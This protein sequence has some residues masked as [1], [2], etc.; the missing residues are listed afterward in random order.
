MTDLYA[1][2]G[3]P[4]SHSKSPLI[5]K[6]FAEVLGQD[7][8]Y[9][10]IE[11]PLG[12]FAETVDAWRAKGLRGLNITVPFKMDAFAYAT[13]RDAAA[14]EAGAVNCLTFEGD[15]AEGANFDGIGLARDIEANLRFAVAGK[16][17]L[18]LGTG[19]ATRGALGPLLAREPARLTV[20]FRTP[21][22]EA[23]LRA[24]FPQAKALDFVAYGDLRDAYD[25]V[26]NATSATLSGE[27]PP[28]PA[29]SFARGAL[30]YDLAYG[31][32]LT[33]FLRLAR[34]AGV[35][36]CVDGVGMLV[37]QA[38]EAFQRWRGVRPETRAMIEKITVPLV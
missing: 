1:V 37:E 33:P 21:G 11:G 20:A 14:E 16:N 18:V 31:K 25:L 4:I 5:H 26:L 2:I 13:R 38:A 17:V 35:D 24:L 22:K 30:A 9:I 12:R 36:R 23:E 8:D 6:G 19:G 32:G 3:N 10:A 29:K 27:A 34:E 28:V 15:T 7:L